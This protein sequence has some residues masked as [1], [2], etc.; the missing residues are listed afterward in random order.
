MAHKGLLDHREVRIVVASRRVTDLADGTYFTCSQTADDAVAE[1]G[2]NGAV[3]ITKTGASLWEGS[4]TLMASSPFNA[5]FDATRKLWIST[6]GGFPIPFALMHKT[7]QLF[8][9]SMIFKKPPAI[10][11]A[12]T[13][14]GTREW[15]LILPGYD[16][17]IGGFEL[18]S[19]APIPEAIYAALAPA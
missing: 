2:V 18:D 5:F 16:G 11:Y 17:I 19:T 10:S 15:G 12:R 4:I 8:S 7:T 14:A 6:P 13:S 9:S 3:V 1:E